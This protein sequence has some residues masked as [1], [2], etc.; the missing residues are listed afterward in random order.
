M[1][2]NNLWSNSIAKLEWSHVLDAVTPYAGS[3]PYDWDNRQGRCLVVG[4][5]S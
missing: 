2:Y 5:S 4:C 1:D 3:V